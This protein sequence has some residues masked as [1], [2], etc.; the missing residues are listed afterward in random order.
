MTELEWFTLRFFSFTIVVLLS[1]IFIHGLKTKLCTTTVCVLGA[2][3]N[4]L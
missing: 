3:L 2:S 4:D 1:F